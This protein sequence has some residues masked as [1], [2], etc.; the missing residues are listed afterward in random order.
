M[1]LVSIIGTV[2]NIVKYTLISVWWYVKKRLL[3][4]FETLESLLSL[5]NITAFQNEDIVR[6]F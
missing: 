6:L 1:M 5:H 3:V 2:V 4:K